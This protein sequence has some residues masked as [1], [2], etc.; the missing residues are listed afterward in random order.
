MKFN[1]RKISAVLASGIMAVSGI[2][3]AA[4]ASYPA[5]FVSAGTADVAIVYGTGSGVSALDVVEAGNIQS[6]LQSRMDT[7]TGST[8]T[9]VT[10]GDSVLISKASDNLNLL[11]NW[12]IFT[13]TV[14][15]DDLS[16][17]LADGTYIADDNDEFN[18]EQKIKLG[19]PANLTHFRDSDYENLIGADENTPAVGF[20]I[21][22]SK[23]I[24]NYTLDFTTDAESDIVSGEM[25]DIEGSDLPL[26]G[27]TY[28]VSD[29]DNGTSTQYFGK[30]TLLD[31]AEV[32]YV[33]EDETTTITVG[34]SSYDVTLTWADADEVIFDVNGERAPAS[35]KLTKGGSYKLDDG[36]YIGVRDIS[37]LEVSGESGNAAF[38]IGSGK[39]EITSDSEIKLN[40]DTISGI[41]GYVHRGTAASAAEKVDK[42][43]IEW[44]T[45]EEVFISPEVELLMPGFEI[46]KFSMDDLVRSEEEK[47]SIE[48]DGGDSIELK[49]PIKDGT[50]SF[51][52]LYANSSSNGNFSGLG[53]SSTER[54]ATSG[55]NTLTFKEKLDG[56]Y[57]AYF[58]ASYN[59][60]KEG[61]SHLLRAHMTKNTDNNN[62][63]ETTIS[64]YNGETS[65]WEEVCGPKIAGEDCTVGQ[66]NFN[67]AE[68]N[69]T[70]GGENR[71]VVL[72]S[73]TN[74]NFNTLYTNG[75]L[76]IYLP[77]EGPVNNAAVPTKGVINFSVSNNTKDGY[78]RDKWW[79]FM[80]GEDKDDTIASGAGFN[81]T[82]D[83]D[84][85]FDLE[86]SEVNHAGS[87]GSGGL[88]IGETDVYEAYMTD[89]GGDV[90]PRVLHNTPS[91]SRDSA[92]VYYPTGDSETY[93]QLYLTEAGAT[94]V[95]GTTGTT[96][97]TVGELGEVLVKDSDVSDVA[98]KNLIIV[99]G[100]CINAAAASVLGGAYCGE[101][102][103][104]ATGVGAGEFLLKGVSDSDVTSGLALVVAGYEAADTV[105]A[106]KYL[107]TQMPDTSTSMIGT[108]STSA[109]LVVEGADDAD[110]EEDADEDADADADEDADA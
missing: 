7:S 36:A 53:K 93:A 57:H 99:G 58:V 10:G 102:F 80:A 95:S 21:G 33:N 87:A 105:N 14:D 110:V 1:F 55:T 75:G 83:Q 63:N 16:V 41:K 6:D 100:S 104:D 98:E 38:S 26:F 11:N 66:V 8:D 101:G 3:F 5:P 62:R 47:V 56:E 103:T 29:F 61:E 2:G 84:S 35:G 51:N 31:A 71:S 97:T 30:L 28:Y 40:D 27:K 108:S 42:I 24:L 91:S 52:I 59:I 12:G 90:A 85:S 88:E 20:K 44:K 22:S 106:A 74:V 43:V 54:L 81:F 86:V 32:G 15:N 65:A 77:Y 60:S 78:N 68:V 64:K 48:Y 23:F 18:Y 92:D 39:L 37:R 50:V 69:Y 109:E 67:I 19:T 25:E 4:A 45:D 70:N 89:G 9:T 49:A 72:T 46:L 96:G 107:R 13:G 82:L 94:I 73:G 79:L 34:D 76:K 17:L